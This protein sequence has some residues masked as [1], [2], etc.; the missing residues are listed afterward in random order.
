MQAKTF[1]LEPEFLEIYLRE[2]GVQTPV[3][4]THS[5]HSTKQSAP[6]QK[7]QQHTAEHTNLESMAL[8]AMQCQKCDLAQ[9]RQHVIF[10]QGNEN[11]DILFII[12]PPSS[13]DDQQGNSLLGQ[14][15]TIFNAMLTAISS[16]RKNIYSLNIVQCAPPNHRD[17]TINELVACQYWLDKQLNLVSP[18]VICVM[19][20][21]A[22]QAL[23]KSH[24][25]L[26]DLREQWHDY[27]GISVRVSYSLTYLLRSPKHKGKV[28][29]DLLAIRKALNA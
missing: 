5:E 22:A 11:A 18:K 17:P 24:A 16:S 28:W 21:V 14:D 4:L 8:Q 25:T 23:L 20:R 12:D 6:F 27:Q 10:G 15:A 29:E 13:N 1:M 2:I 7:E 19:G 9:S 26:R 3:S